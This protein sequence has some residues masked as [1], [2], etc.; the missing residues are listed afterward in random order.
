MAHYY[1]GA[2]EESISP[3]AIQP[4]ISTGAPWAGGAHLAGGAPWAVGAPCTA[5][6]RLRAAGCTAG[7]RAVNV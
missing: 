3:S 1:S 6:G 4:V 5:T 2:C 7:M